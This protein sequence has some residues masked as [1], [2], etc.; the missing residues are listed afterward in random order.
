MRAIH[1]KVTLSLL[2]GI[3]IFIQ[4]CPSSDD[5]D[6]LAGS[7]DNINV[8]LVNVSNN[9]I[10]IL[11][12]GEGFAASNRLGPCCT[13]THTRNTTVRGITDGYGVQFRAGTSG[14]VSVTVTC[15]YDVQTGQI[16]TVEYQGGPLAC[17]DW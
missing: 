9:Y 1:H 13:D 10:H 3:P 8:R 12:E 15:T 17:I 14:T 16:R 4:G 5:E 2:L 7:L 11:A 6:F